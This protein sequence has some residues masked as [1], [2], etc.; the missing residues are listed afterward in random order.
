MTAIKLDT[1]GIGLE[2]EAKDEVGRRVA[3]QDV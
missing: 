1:S 2:E 3:M